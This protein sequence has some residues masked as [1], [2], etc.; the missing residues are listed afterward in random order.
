MT[1]L[2]LALAGLAGYA[3]GFGTHRAIVGNVRRDFLELLVDAR[4]AHAGTER[5]LRAATL[6]IE[7]LLPDAVVGRKRL[8]ALARANA[9]KRAARAAAK[10]AR[11]KS[12]A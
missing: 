3:L 10:V 12:A 9:K 8:Q 5:G 2:I 4:D 6:R 1:P 11:I 7:Q